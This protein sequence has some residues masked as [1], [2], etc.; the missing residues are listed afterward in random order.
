MSE[1]ASPAEIEVTPEMMEAGELALTE[2]EPA[3]E[4]W[5]AA[6][7]R[8]FCRMLR[9]GGYSVRFRKMAAASSDD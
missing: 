1:P 6:V 9:A 7:R 5:D 4:G 2:Y 3:F 8:I